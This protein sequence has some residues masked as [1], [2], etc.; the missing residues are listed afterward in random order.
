MLF[1]IEKTEGMFGGGVTKVVPVTERGGGKAREEHVPR[2]VGRNFPGIFAAFQ[3]KTQAEG[4]GPFSETE[5]NF[6]HSEPG[7]AKGF[8]PGLNGGYFF[9][10]KRAGAELACKGERFEWIVE[11][12][13]AGRAKVKNNEASSDRSSSFER[14]QRV[15]LGKKTRGGAGVGKFV[16]VGV[17]AE[18]FD[19][20]GTKVVKDIDLWGVGHFMFGQNS[21][22][23]AEPGIMT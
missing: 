14:G 6:F 7:F 2:I 19:R 16:C 22:P 12:A 5:K 20:D 10:N 15:A 3:T 8:F 13:W 9:S 18:E 11:V 21:G 23:E 1:M 17:G 4:L